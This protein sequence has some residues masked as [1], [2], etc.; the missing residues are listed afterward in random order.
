MNDT[1]FALSSGAPP[2]AIAVVRVSGPR[3]ASVP[4]ALGA[5]I[6]AP[7][8]AALRTLRGS[9]GEVLDRALV[10]WLPGPANA[11]GEDCI[12][13]HC[14]GGRAVVA[15]L[16]RELAALPGLREA[17]PGEF[18]RRAFANGRIDLAQAEALGDLLAAETELQRRVAQSGVGGRV[19]NMVESWRDRVLG[20]SAM[21]EAVLDFSD[22][23][24]V[25]ALPPA[26][27]ERRE[28]LRREIA[29]SLA[30]PRAERL[31]DGIR[32]VIAG[33]PN[34]G[35]SSLFNALVGDGA[36]I[37]SSVAGTTRDVIERPVAFGGLPFVLADTAGLRGEG[38]EEIEAIGIARA[39]HQLDRA[40]IVLWLGEEG[41]GPPNAIEVQARCD[42]PGAPA[43]LQPD[44]VVSSVTGEGL[45]TLEADLQR[46][47]RD[48]L[49]T[50]GSVAVN[51]R[52]ARLLRQAEEALGI[53]S[54]DALLLA[55]SLRIARA[56]FDSLLGRAG[57]EDMLDALF[58]RFCIGK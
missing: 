12:E 4:E 26:F 55:E 35:K 15:A 53:E 2:A 28:A 36:A 57:V 48:I 46:R 24:D 33:P 38:A 8:R 56:S 6:P 32:V 51:E 47:A 44:H 27:A 31:R 43:K 37:V 54:E 41:R 1:I 22:E 25:A 21:V 7:R 30:L 16:R 11:T 42:D 19:S 17:E 3:A 10:L 49:P 50:P 20:L 39:Q 58:A 45:A 40:D 52:Q 13:L 18:T 29:A 5:A 14:H 9:D 34:A 23:D